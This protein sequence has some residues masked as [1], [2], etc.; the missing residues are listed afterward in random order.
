MSDGCQIDDRGQR[1]FKHKKVNKSMQQYTFKQGD[2]VKYD[3]QVI[4]GIGK[5]CGICT[6]SQAV[7]GATYIIEDMTL[8]VPND[9]YQY[10]HFACAEC[11]LTLVKSSVKF[12]KKPENHENKV[13][14]A[15]YVQDEG[16]EE[17]KMPRCIIN[18][19]K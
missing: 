8:K 9:T 7:I 11:F 13:V 15:K 19:M 5:I 12:G 16:K 4:N 14:F 2:I 6:I 10:T 18:D 1:P 3:N 17:V